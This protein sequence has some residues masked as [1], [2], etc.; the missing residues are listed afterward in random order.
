VSASGSVAIT[1]SIANSI[2]FVSANPESI[3]IKGTGGGG[4][5][6]NSALTFQVVDENGVAKEGVPVSF[7]LSTT[8]GGVSLA[9]DLDGDG[10]MDGSEQKN[11]NASGNVTV[12]VNAGTAVTPVRVTASFVANDGSTI[13]IVSDALTI[14]TGLPDQNSFSLSA[15]VRNPGGWEVNGIESTVDSIEITIEPPDGVGG[16]SVFSSFLCTDNN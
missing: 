12:T 1:E 16:V 10:D 13:S 11:T 4:R 8:T 5:Q 6:E 14:S 9:G 3:A 2:K 15:S 7:A